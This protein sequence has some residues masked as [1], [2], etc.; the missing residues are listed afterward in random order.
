M[1]SHTGEV[2]GTKTVGKFVKKSHNGFHIYEV[3]CSACGKTE[4]RRYQKSDLK[5]RCVCRT[6]KSFDYEDISCGYL[7][8]IKKRARLKGH[9]YSVSAKYLWELYEAQGGKCSI[10]GEPIGFVK[11]Y[12]KNERLQTAS[13]DRI[14]SSKGYI[15]GNLQWVHKYVNNM[16]MSLDQGVFIRMCKKISENNEVTY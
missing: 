1:K 14:D 6:R 7:T 8:G 11:P 2:F 15:E 13:L 16:K 4:E 5:C 3:F 9:E 12:A 10:S